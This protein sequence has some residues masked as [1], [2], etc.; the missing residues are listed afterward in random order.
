MGFPGGS[1]VKNQP[2]M[3]ENQVQS[4]GQKD[5]LEKEI[6]T[7]TSIFAWEISRAKER[8]GLQ[9][10]ELLEPDVTEQLSHHHLDDM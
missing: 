2:A 10:R 7:H 3:Q 5:P 4:L 9:T 6:A 8:N 1:A